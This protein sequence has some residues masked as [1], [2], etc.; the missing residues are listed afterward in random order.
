MLSNKNYYI[1]LYNK[2]KIKYIAFVLL[3]LFSIFSFSYF[4]LLGFN[5]KYEKESMEIILNNDLISLDTNKE[6][7]NKNDYL[8]G[9]DII[10]W[11]NLDKATDRRK[12]M[13]TIFKDNVFNNIKIER[14]K[15]VDGKNEDINKYIH[16]FSNNKN[17]S[18][19]Y[20]CTLSHLN[21]IRIFSESQ[22]KIAL[23]L[24]DDTTLE[25]KKYWKSNIENVI[26]NAPK[27]WDIIQL[28]IV[29]NNNETK[30]INN[31]N[32][33]ILNNNIEYYSTGSY[34]I[35]NNSANKVHNIYKNNRFNL[36]IYDNIAADIFVYK[37]FKTYVY[38]Y[39]Y[40]T[41][42]TNKSY[43]HEE[44]LKF[45]IYSKNIITNYLNSTL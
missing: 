13:E 45:Q 24:E 32:N 25:Y 8:N 33:Y 26:N 22:Y 29:L 38:K 42:L 41:Y 12:H 34:I 30:Y 1:K 44:D 18:L 43:I 27:D 15:A 4:L 7:L 3:L 37:Y 39:P 11:I 16:T 10:Y 14:I 21:T 5:K 17:T 35:N 23:I 28:N 20:A 2:I 9:I 6:I 40:F 19:E 31:K 36:S